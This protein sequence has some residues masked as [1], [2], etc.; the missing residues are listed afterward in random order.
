MKLLKQ[1][2]YRFIIGALA[3]AFIGILEIWFYEFSLRRLIAAAVSGA[4]FFAILGVASSWAARKLL[5]SCLTIFAGGATAAAVWWLIA[6]PEVS[7]SISIALGIGFSFLFLVGERMS[8][9]K[10]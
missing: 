10:S 2:G 3:G 1:I 7:L 4:I 5:N 9:P 6:R 8:K